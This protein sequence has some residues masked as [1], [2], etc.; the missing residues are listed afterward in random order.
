MI[1]YIMIIFLI[2][3]SAG[4]KSQALQRRFL[5]FFNMTNLGPVDCQLSPAAPSPDLS[6]PSFPAVFSASPRGILNDI[7][8]TCFGNKPIHLHT[9]IA[10]QRRPGSTRAA[11]LLY[12]KRVSPRLLHGAGRQ[13]L[14]PTSRFSLPGWRFAG[15]SAFS[16]CEAALGPGSPLSFP[17]ETWCG[18]VLQWSLHHTLPQQTLSLIPAPWWPDLALRFFRPPQ[19]LSLVGYGACAALILGSCHFKITCPL[20]IR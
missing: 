16:S 12:C 15:S 10:E 7:W 20:C 9:K 3:Y 19:P 11:L 8:T 1:I 4:A 5:L 18:P 14:P 2:L 13:F 17:P 6:S